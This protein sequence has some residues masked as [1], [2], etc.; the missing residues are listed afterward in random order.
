M[1]SLS[2]LIKL[3]K[4]HVDE[5][6]VQ[7][8]KLQAQLDEVERAIAELEIK[9]AR[10]QVAAEQNPEARTTY[11]AFLKK[12]VIQGRELEKQRMV[13]VIA[14]ELARDK[15]TE[16][17][18]EQKRYEVAE[19]ARVESEAREERRRERIQLDEFG[20]MTHERKKAE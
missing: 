9:K 12:A 13:A 5:Q 15:L 17:F 2:T 20:G 6:R 19:A 7:L 4:T 16:L 18:E 3:Q 8:A 1:K 14:V 11:G 10:E